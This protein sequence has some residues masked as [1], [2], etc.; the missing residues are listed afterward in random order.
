MQQPAAEQREENRADFDE[1]CGGARVDVTFA[2]AERDHIQPEPEQPEPRILG[3]AARVGQPSPLSSHTTPRV[4]GAANRR[5]QRERVRQPRAASGPIVTLC[6]RNRLTAGDRKSWTGSWTEPSVQ[7]VQSGPSVARL[8]GIRAAS[9]CDARGRSSHNPPVVGSSPT[10][11]TCDLV[12]RHP[13][14]RGRG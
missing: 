14:R 7:T 5:P 13:G 2:P 3:H 12:P 11:P 4:S 9:A 10:R 8:R 6:S 1:H